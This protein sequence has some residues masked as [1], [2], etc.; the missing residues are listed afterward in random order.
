MGEI[1]AKSTA[2]SRNTHLDSRILQTLSK[3]RTF[4]TAILSDYAHLG[5]IRAKS[6]AVSR[7]LGD[8]FTLFCSNWAFAGRKDEKV[9]Q[10]RLFSPENFRR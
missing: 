9:T 2:I 5:E 4:F 7:N 10:K 3:I 1:R 6:T 8:D